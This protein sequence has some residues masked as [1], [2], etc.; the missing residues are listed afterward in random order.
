[1]PLTYRHATPADLPFIV[2]LVV[3]GII[4]PTEDDPAD[5]MNADYVNALAAIDRDPNQEMFVVAFEG[6]PIGCFQLS[7]IPGLMRRGMTRGQIELVHIEAAHRNRGF[8]TEMMRWAIA[9]CSEKGCGM[10]QLTS[11]KKRT[12]AHRFYNRLGFQQ[13]HEGFK[14]FL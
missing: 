8:G 13:S 11:N 6:R 5:A 14:L 12:D 7:Y 3:D 1:M 9:R 4:V 10:V 2:R